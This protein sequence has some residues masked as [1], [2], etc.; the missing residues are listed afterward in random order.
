MRPKSRY[1]RSHRLLILWCCLA[2][3][4]VFAGYK[5]RPWSPRAPET[6]PARLTSEK[7]TIAAEPLIQDSQ[8]AQVFDKNDMVTAGI[9]PIAIVIFNDN[10]FP[11]RVEAA[12]IE[13]ILSDEHTHTLPPAE[14]A[15]GL[16]K[17]GKQDVWGVPAS[18]LPTGK[19]GNADAVRD[20]EQKFLSSK[21]VP[22][23]GKD[24][25]FLYIH[26]RTSEDLAT[27]L[28]NASIY[29]P[30]IFREDNGSKMIFFEFDLKPA[31]DNA[32]TK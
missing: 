21:V 29:I 4:A 27:V 3:V 9:M 7:V 12:T 23:H 18:R 26:P 22:A 8:A 10:D 31:L 20:F 32:R 2:S 14:V 28:A 30:D 6:Y 24:G 15:Y 11:V 13:I 16:F 5:A 19:I 17:K 1:L 25:G